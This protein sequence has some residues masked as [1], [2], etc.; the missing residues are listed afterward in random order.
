[1]AEYKEVFTLF[2][3]DRNGILSFTET[4]LAVRTLGQWCTGGQLVIRIKDLSSHRIYQDKLN[5]PELT[6]IQY[7]LIFSKIL[8]LVYFR[9]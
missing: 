1:M 3:K 8:L 2:D 7:I 5:M 6:I 4:K 9:Q